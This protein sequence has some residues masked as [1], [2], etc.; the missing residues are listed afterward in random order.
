[1]TK[2]YKYRKLHNLKD[3]GAWYFTE[4]SDG[5]L[6]SSLARTGAELARQ[7]GVGDRIMICGSLD[8]MTRGYVEEPLS[9]GWEFAREYVHKFRSP[10]YRKDGRTVAVKLA[11]ESW[12]PGCEKAKDAALAWR[13]L[14]EW[15]SKTTSLPL[16]ST[17]SKTGQ[18]LLWESFPRGKSFPSLSEECEQVV[19]RNSTQHRLQVFKPGYKGK[20]VC[21]DGRW[22]YSAL[23]TA[24]RF[25]VGNAVYMKHG[26]NS[27]DFV[28]YVPGWY[29]CYIEVPSGWD[30]IGLV[31]FLGE[32]GWFYPDSRHCSFTTW[33][34][35]PELTLAQQNGWHI[36]VMES[37][38]FDKGKPLQ[39]WAHK[40]QNLRDQLKERN[41]DFAAAAVR[42]ILNSTI[43]SLHSSG[44]EREQ[45]V[46]DADLR[47]WSRANPHLTDR[48]LEAVDGGYLV[49]VLVPDN[50]PLSIVMPH[51][52]ATIWAL[53]RAAVAKQALRCDP[54]TLIEIR[55][56]AIYST[57]P[58]PFHGEDNGNYG[59]L[60]FKGVSDASEA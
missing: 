24:D 35:E 22:M 38:T 26:D 52:S 25:P 21:Y 6:S 41:H 20:R 42:Q 54:D 4:V 17:P 60:R 43:G 44:Y 39:N 9:C 2:T 3:L 51:W 16:L 18:A 50:S 14:K 40:L 10:V 53:E 15:W 56:D 11:S 5:P 45:F 34:A 55:G 58:L 31:P 48:E 13:A 59:Q 27:C 8:E 1:M 29:R 47:A 30:H 37:Y 23:A 49:P 32:N 28:P 46:A 57:V 7:F 36:E 12:F 33:A 19:R